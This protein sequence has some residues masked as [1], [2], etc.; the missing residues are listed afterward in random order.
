MSTKAG[1]HGKT[2]AT[3]V[4]RSTLVRALQGVADVYS[5][6]GSEQ[7]FIE[8]AASAGDSGFTVT[9]AKPLADAVLPAVDE[10][11]TQPA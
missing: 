4:P 11:P 1:V 2:E 6:N 9:G 5:T 8:A 10:E 3:R 7:P